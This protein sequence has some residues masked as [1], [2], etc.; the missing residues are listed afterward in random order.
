MRV[1]VDR[2]EG[3]LAV[4]ELPDRTMLNMPRSLLPGETKEGDVIDINVNEAAT[5][6]RRE[7]ISKLIE[8]LW[9]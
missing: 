2:F 1:I 8:E 4:V 9:E 5:Q 7:T 6:K 3:E